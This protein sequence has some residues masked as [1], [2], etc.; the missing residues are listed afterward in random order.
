MQ[1]RMPQGKTFF[2]SAFGRV[3]DRFGLSF[4]VIVPT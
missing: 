4:I 1:V 2:A 3:A